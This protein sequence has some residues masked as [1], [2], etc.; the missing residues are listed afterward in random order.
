MNQ[1]ALTQLRCEKQLKIV[2]GAAG[3]FSR[4]KTPRTQPRRAGHAG[5]SD[6]IL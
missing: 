5:D 2:P 3:H 4:K 1:E 6:K